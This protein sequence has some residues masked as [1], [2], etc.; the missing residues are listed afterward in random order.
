MK[1]KKN[2]FLDYIPQIHPDITW[3]ENNKKRITIH[4][5]NKG[6]YNRVAQFFLKRPKI[7]H[8][9]LD[10]YGSFLWKHITG[11]STV[12]DLGRRMKESFGE[13]AEPL[14][15]RLIKYLQILRNNRFIILEKKDRI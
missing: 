13:Q 4:V 10:E 9:D 1:K 11:N 12:E 7:S 6:F 15:E 14:Y 3:D 5:K 2:N 8:I